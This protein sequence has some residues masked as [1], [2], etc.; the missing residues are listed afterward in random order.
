MG[1]GKEGLETAKVRGCHFTVLSPLQ[2]GADVHTQ[3]CERAPVEWGV[4][5]WSTPGLWYLI[6]LAQFSSPSS[7]PRARAH[8]LGLVRALWAA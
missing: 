1:R 4:R 7:L 5:L 6:P 8:M 3:T 2:V